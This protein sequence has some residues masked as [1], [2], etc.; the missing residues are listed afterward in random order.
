MRRSKILEKIRAGQTAKLT[1][2]GYFLPPYVA[3]AAHLGFDGIW[4]DL[5]HRA[6]DQRELQS[7]LAFFHRY[8]IDCLLRPATREKALLYRYLEDGVTG[9]VVPHVTTADEARALVK[10]VKFPPVGDRGMNPTGLEVDY[11]VT[12][13]RETLIDHALKETFLLVMLES[14]EAVRNAESIAAIEGLDGLFIGPSDLGIRTALE[15]EA[16]RISYG[17]TMTRVAEV[18]E[19]HNKIW[20]TTS[21]TVDDLRELRRRKASFLMWGTDIHILRAGL[22]LAAQDIADVLAE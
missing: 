18:C 22:T 5:E 12:G 21:Q 13:N 10:A 4:L 6:Y 20:G 8:D 14:P 15:P 17:E 1:M 3:Y 2:M 11:G 7:I 19:R 16:T 9:F